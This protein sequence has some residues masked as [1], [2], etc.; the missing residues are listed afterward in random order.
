ML[1][2]A[3]TFLTVALAAGFLGF[4]DIA[5]ISVEFARLIFVVFLVLFVTTAFAHA[6]QGRAPSA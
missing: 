2:W 5:A 3:L 6:L 4:G 1:Q